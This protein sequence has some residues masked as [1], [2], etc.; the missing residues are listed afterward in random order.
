MICSWASKILSDLLVNALHDAFQIYFIFATGSSKLQGRREL[1]DECRTASCGVFVLHQRGR[2]K[3]HKNV[4]KEQVRK[5]PASHS[6]A[7][8]DCFNLKCSLKRPIWELC[9]LVI[10]QSD[11]ESFDLGVVS[12]RRSV[13]SLFTHKQDEMSTLPHG[14]WGK[15]RKRLKC[16]SRNVDISASKT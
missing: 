2:V 6:N 16:V 5:E 14:F 10:L 7:T 11:C 1:R 15:T 8:R 9:S 13:N 3:T 4:F 12:G